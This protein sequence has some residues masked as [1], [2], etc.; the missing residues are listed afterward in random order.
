MEELVSRFPE[1]A[2]VDDLGLE[3]QVRIFQSA[4]DA[5]QKELHGQD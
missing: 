3:E 5:L 2:R 4:L 1:L